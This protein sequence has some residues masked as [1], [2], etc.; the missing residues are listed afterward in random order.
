MDLGS[1]FSSNQR[2]LA[3]ALG[4]LATK[5]DLVGT[6]SRSSSAARNNDSGGQLAAVHEVRVQAS[7]VVVILTATGNDARGP[8]RRQIAMLP[9][10]AI[11]LVFDR[12]QLGLVADELEHAFGSRRRR[13]ARDVLVKQGAAKVGAGAV[14]GLRG[15]HSHAGQKGKEKLKQG[16]LHVVGGC[17]LVLFR[18][19]R[20]LRFGFVKVA[21]CILAKSFSR[22]P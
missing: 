19:R 5:Y 2:Y 1:S 6:P 20:C 10:G 13:D 3:P 14:D 21:G 16:G 7:P 8:A 4:R 12:I 17:G 22:A 11:L 9:V 18:L 15:G